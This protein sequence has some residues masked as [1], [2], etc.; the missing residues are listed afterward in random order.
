MRLINIF[1]R[2]LQLRSLETTLRKHL[3]IIINILFLSCD[4]DFEYS[5]PIFTGY[6]GL[7]SLPSDQVWLKQIKRLKDIVDS[8]FIYISPG[9]DLDVEDSRPILPH[10]TPVHDNTPP[11]QVCLHYIEQFRRYH[12]DKIQTH[13]QMDVMIPIYPPPP[14]PTKLCYRAG[15]G[16]RV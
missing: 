10:D 13:R 5:N 3:N 9:C 6:S 11:Y 8:H 15:G 4:L 16:D 14:H 12:P 1:S 7:R 2:F